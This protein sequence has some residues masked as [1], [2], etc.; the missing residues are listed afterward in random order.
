MDQSLVDLASEVTRSLLTA[1]RLHALS[2]SDA[3]PPRVK[4]FC[5]ICGITILDSDAT[6]LTCGSRT[7]LNRMAKEWNDLNKD[8][9]D[10]KLDKTGLTEQV[11]DLEHIILALALSIGVDVE[12]FKEVV[13]GNESVKKVNFEKVLVETMKTIRSIRDANLK[14]KDYISKLKVG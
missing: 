9:E 5:S 11:E 8:L 12:P 3:R 1:Q 4:P 7:C 10:I 6:G 13:E 2:I 14:I